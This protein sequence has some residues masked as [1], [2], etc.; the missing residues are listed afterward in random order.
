MIK[1]YA[2]YKKY[3][4]EEDT[5]GVTVLDQFSDRDNVSSWAKKALAWAVKEHLIG[6]YTDGTIL[7]KETTNRAE[8]SVVIAKFCDVFQNPGSVD[9]AM[10][11]SINHMGFNLTTPENT[12]WSFDA[13][14]FN[15][16]NYVETDVRLTKDRVPVL[17][18]DAT[19][20]RTARNADGSKLQGNVYLS[21]L[22]FD[23][24]RKYDFGLFYNEKYKGNL[25]TRSHTAMF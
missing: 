9:W 19:I 17:L 22:T 13:A 23:E 21:S 2:K 5:T 3:I 15:G 4:R 14:K 20:N 12:E 10:V 16:F 6:G 11:R 1:N 24:V 25:C 7:P 8:V 18:H